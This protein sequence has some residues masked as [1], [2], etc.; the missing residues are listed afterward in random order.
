MG[1]LPFGAALMTRYS[2]PLLACRRTAPPDSILLASQLHTRMHTSACCPFHTASIHPS[3]LQDFLALYYA[4]S[5]V[6]L[7]QRDLYELADAY[8]ARAAAEGV[9]HAE[10]FFDPQAHTSR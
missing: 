6:L 5:S 10:L 4:G 3:P 7:T 1:L 9:R 2:C 8:L